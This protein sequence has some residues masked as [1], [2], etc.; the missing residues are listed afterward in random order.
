MNNDYI[1]S[2]ERL[3]LCKETIISKIFVYV[4]LFI[5]VYVV[6]NEL[7]NTLGAL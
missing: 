7:L 3:K 2:K 1:T 4:I 6:I 5:T